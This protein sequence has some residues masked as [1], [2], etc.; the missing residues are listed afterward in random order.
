LL[1]FCLA[2]SLFWTPAFAKIENKEALLEQA[3]LLARHKKFSDAYTHFKKLAEHGCPYS[4]CVLGIMHK[5]GIGTEK[6]AVAAAGWFEQ[7]AHQGFADAER[8][9]GHLY[10]IGEGV[11][12]DEAKAAEWLREAAKHGVVEAQYELGNLLAK[13][14][15]PEKLAEGGEWLKKASEKGLEASETAVEKIPPVTSSGYQGDPN[16]YS[17][18]VTNITQAWQG[19]TNLAKTLQTTTS[20]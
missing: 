12:K 19:Y 4:Q 7:S 17:T 10:S 8:W 6:D 20:Q 2:S 13:S 3:S 11:P 1:V 16:S 15:A 14:D 5:N 18:G 9:L